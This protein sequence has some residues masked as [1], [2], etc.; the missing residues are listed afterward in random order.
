M[1]KFAHFEDVPAQNISQLYSKHAEIARQIH[2]DALREFTSNDE[3]VVDLVEKNALVPDEET[4]EIMA[5]YDAIS[6]SSSM[7]LG[8]IF[9]ID[10][11]DNIPQYK[12][13]FEG[14]APIYIVSAGND[15]RSGVT[16]SPRMADFSRNS[17]VVGEANVQNRNEPMIEVHSSQTNV[18]LAADSPFNNGIRYQYYDF[19]PSLD[20]HEDLLLDYMTDEEFKRRY[21][22]YFADKGTTAKEYFEKHGR[23]SFW[24]VREIIQKGFNEEEFRQSPETLTRLENYMQNPDEFHQIM[25]EKIRSNSALEID[26]NGFVTGIDGTSFS[27]PHMAGHISGALYEQSQREEQGLPILTKEELSAL[28]KLATLDVEHRED[29]TEVLESQMNAAGFVSTIPGGH[30]VFDPE[31]FRDLLDKAY[32]HLETNP[33]ILRES[34]TVIIEG[35]FEMGLNGDQPVS[36]ALGSENGGIVIDRMLLEMKY[37]VNGIPPYDI[38]MTH[39]NGS[40]TEEKLAHMSAS[41]DYDNRFVR[42]EDRFGEALQGENQTWQFQLV[43]GKDATYEDNSVNLTI[44]GWPQNGLI[45]QMMEYSKIIAPEHSLQ[46]KTLLQEES[47]V[48]DHDQNV[49]ELSPIV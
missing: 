6:V 44:Y 31:M 24:E 30:G 41:D 5:E 22:E 23:D 15:G 4:L 37:T 13:F 45:H 47:P 10:A 3:L 25:T 16:N 18:T 33:D 28:A 29:Q 11:A 26:E 19:S 21:D 35:D 39:P 17:L 14:D 9:G 7:G 34:K 40:V 32:E 38:V 48:T 20:G 1:D 43:K 49:N 27:A 12:T 42:I 46:P 2:Q 36:L 8:S